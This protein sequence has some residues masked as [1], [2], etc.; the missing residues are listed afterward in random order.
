MNRVN[1]GMNDNN[2]V[3]FDLGVT[4]YGSY[5]YSHSM[6]NYTF[7]YFR[8]TK[9]RSRSTKARFRSTKATTRSRLL[10]LHWEKWRY[11]YCIEACVIKYWHAC[12]PQSFPHP[13]P[14]SAIPTSC[15]VAMHI[16]TA[17]GTTLSYI[18]GRRKPPPDPGFRY[19]GTEKSEGTCTV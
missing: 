15:L 5:A 9:A 16:P 18:S 12:N 13:L 14:V 11:M 1:I 7:L 6:R 19:P 2:Y 4:V 17:W 10:L 3:H 8:S